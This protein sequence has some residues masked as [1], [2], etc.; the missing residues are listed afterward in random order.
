MGS[1]PRASAANVETWRMLIGKAG[2]EASAVSR[3]EKPLRRGAPQRSQPVHRA[4]SEKSL[5]RAAGRQPY[6]SA[7]G[8]SAK[9]RSTGAVMW[10]Q[11]HPGAVR[12]VGVLMVRASLLLWS[13]S[14]GP[15]GVDEQTSAQP[16]Q[17][18]VWLEKRSRTYATRSSWWACPRQAGASSRRRWGGF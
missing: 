7:S 15:P 8:R 17:L 4:G 16:G 5:R 10:Y 2:N 13:F 12:S 6:Q 14:S 9:R 3:V 1:S 11:P 18:S